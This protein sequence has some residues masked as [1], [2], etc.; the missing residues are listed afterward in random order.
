MRTALLEDRP[1]QTNL[2]DSGGFAHFGVHSWPSLGLKACLCRFSVALFDEK[3][4][5][6]HGV[7]CG[8]SLSGA[9][10]KRRAEF[11]AGRL[12]AAQALRHLGAL[13]SVLAGADRSPVWPAGMIGSITHCDE[14]AMAIAL[15]KEHFRGVGIDLER[16]TACRDASLDVRHF[17][18]DAERG[19]LERA[20]IACED[21]AVIA[22]SMKE[23]FFKAA[24]PH[25]GHYFGFSAVSIV[26]ADRSQRRLAL[27]VA[28]DIGNKL[29]QGL[30]VTG[31]YAYLGEAFVSTVVTIPIPDPYTKPMDSA[32]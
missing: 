6:L 14:T 24:Y 12:C 2:G 16:R 23:S 15:K 1:E 17:A 29:R 30:R 13:E 31:E 28:Q 25:V 10:R 18:T 11:L 21:H 19:V 32:A 8:P 20:G 22:F 4:F 3:L 7:R 26:E 9:V 27:V 5:V